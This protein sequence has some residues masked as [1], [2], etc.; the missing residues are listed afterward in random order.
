MTDEAERNVPQVWD[1]LARVG[2]SLVPVV[3]G[4]A[5]V[6]YEDVRARI[7]ARTARTLDEVVAATG[8]D[9]LS[10]RLAS[11]PELEAVFAQGLDAAARTGYE[12]KR[13]VLSRV[14]SA[15]VLDDARVDEALLVVLALRDLDAPHLRVLEKM[16]RVQDDVLRRD[17]SEFA[18]ESD[19]EAGAE[20]AR[21]KAATRAVV[22]ATSEAPVVLLE[23][24]TRTGVAHQVGMTYGGPVCP[25]RVSDFGRLVLDDLR[26]VDVI[27]ERERPR[28]SR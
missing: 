23:T 9:E 7:A 14:I 12:A 6:V 10:E 27:E 11:D 1:T 25:G 3:G 2:L 22:A 26:D 8:L 20:T 18:N 24:L 28:P 16:R 5:Q 21:N 19:G 4:A 17:L 13:R 15:A